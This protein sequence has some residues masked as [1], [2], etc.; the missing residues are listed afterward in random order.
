MRYSLNQGYAVKPDAGERRDAES[1]KSRR[2][3]SRS[4]QAPKGASCRHS[5]FAANLCA[6][7][8]FYVHLPL[9]LKASFRLKR[10]YPILFVGWLVCLKPGF[11]GETTNYFAQGQA[12]YLAGEFSTATAAFQK[13]TEQRP[14]SGTFVNLGLAE[15]QRG[16]AGEAMLAWERAHWVDPFDSRAMGN[17]QFARQVLQ[18]DEPELKWFEVASTWLPPNTWVWLAGVSL[19]LAVGLVT[20]PGFLRWRK[21]GWQQTVAAISLGVF[22]FAMVANL[23]VVSRTQLGL[24]TR[25][26]AALRLTPTT[27]GEIITTLAAGE[28]ARKLRVC[29]S[30]F[31]IRTASAE[32]WIERKQFALVCPD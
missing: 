3:F 1:A 23:G 18:L 12:A 28:P 8:L 31:F 24:V 29:G 20:L 2:D 15:W 16:H 26:D 10:F 7:L 11:A 4:V 32:G 27:E 22:L 9:V 6:A 13:A 19:W 5:I 14:A 21:A 30:Y 17:L 25:K